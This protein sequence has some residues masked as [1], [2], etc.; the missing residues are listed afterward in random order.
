VPAAAPARWAGPVLAGLAVIL[1]WWLRPLRRC[2]A[3]RFRERAVRLGDLYGIA[4]VLLLILGAAAGTGM[5]MGLIRPD[6]SPLA[7]P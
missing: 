4:A 1:G 5:A 3:T 7:V 6:P 2:L